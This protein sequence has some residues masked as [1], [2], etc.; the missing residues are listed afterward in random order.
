M[1]DKHNPSYIRSLVF[2]SQISANNL[3]QHINYNKEYNEFKHLHCL[4]L[5]HKR[6]QHFHFPLIGL[7][8][9]SK[10]SY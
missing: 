10:L 7:I 9:R 4:K 8:L 5:K 1:N 3:W 2:I 6:K